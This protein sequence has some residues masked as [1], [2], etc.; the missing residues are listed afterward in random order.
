MNVSIDHKNSPRGMEINDGRTVF[1]IA[2]RLST[3]KNSKAI[4]LGNIIERGSHNELIDLKG[5]YYELFT[6]SFE[7]E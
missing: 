4:L 7:L 2:H 6:G 5:T 3:I 1:V